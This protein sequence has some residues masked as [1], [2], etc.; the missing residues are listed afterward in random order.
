MIAAEGS[1]GRV[2]TLRLEDGN[3]R[4]VLVFPAERFSDREMGFSEKV[5]PNEAQR[6]RDDEQFALLDWLFEMAP[7]IVE[8]EEEQTTVPES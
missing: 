6:A 3:R 4:I 7:V 5:T 8:D 2:F 1:V